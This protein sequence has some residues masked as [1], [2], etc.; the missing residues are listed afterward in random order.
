MSLRANQI[1][2]QDLRGNPADLKEPNE[3]QL[4]YHV[5]QNAVIP[6]N[7]KYIEPKI[8]IEPLMREYINKESEE[9]LI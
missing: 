9:L 2:F 6:R 3:S 8:L 1:S 7:D 4:D 5:T